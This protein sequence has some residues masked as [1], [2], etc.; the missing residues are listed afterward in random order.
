MTVFLSVYLKAD[1]FSKVITD[2][3]FD[4]KKFNY[5]FYVLG[6]LFKNKNYEG[7]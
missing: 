3:R 1:L 2:I 5:Y 7:N 4:A 6:E